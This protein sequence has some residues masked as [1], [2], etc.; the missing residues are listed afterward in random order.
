[1]GLSQSRHH[2]AVAVITQPIL[3]H[4]FIEPFLKG[5]TPKGMFE[6]P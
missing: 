5:Q 2:A 3:L 4:A 1:M 6:K